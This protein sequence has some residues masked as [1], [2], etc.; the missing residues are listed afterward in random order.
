MAIKIFTD[1]ASGISS[2]T[3]KELNIGVVELTIIWDGTMEQEIDYPS[4]DLT[5]FYEK[6][7]REIAT[8][9]HPEP[10]RFVSAFKAWLDADP[11]NEIVC[12]TI[13]KEFSHTYF[14]AISAA[15]E[16]DPLGERITIIDSSSVAMGEGW[17]VIAAAKC[18]IA[19]NTRLE[20][21]Q[22][23]DSNKSQAIV[24]FKATDLTA[25]ARGGRIPDV[26][27]AL[28][29]KI[30]LVPIV[31][32]T[33][34]KKPHLVGFSLSN[35]QSF[36]KITN[37]ASSYYGEQKRIRAGII[38]TDKQDE[39]ERMLTAISKKFTIVESVVQQPPRVVGVHTGPF[40]VTGICIFPA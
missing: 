23:V 16:I 8:T 12:I 33:E 4:D 40:G 10:A 34:G 29:R 9:S 19:G 20:I 26:I 30:S 18:V 7:S 5:S 25:L 3:L 28:Q 27:V 38:Y 39:A 13:S 31:G 37:K 35:G 17:Q 1:S 15:E 21:A 2:R 11:I 36:T 6:L 24:L 32:M 22:L 14:S